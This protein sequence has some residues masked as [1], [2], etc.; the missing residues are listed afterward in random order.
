TRSV[1]AWAVATVWEQEKRVAVEGPVVVCNTTTTTTSAA[2]TACAW[3]SA[4]DSTLLAAAA[5][6]APP[7]TAD[8]SVHGFAFAS[9]LL[10]DPSRWDRFPTSEPD[11][12]Q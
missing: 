5:A 12:S 6:A 1:G 7:V 2:S 11:Q 4:S 3:F 8:D 10:W 9:D